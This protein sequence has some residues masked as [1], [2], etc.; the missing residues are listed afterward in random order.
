MAKKISD[1]KV[2]EAEILLGS[3]KRKLRFD[4]EAVAEAELWQK[5]NCGDRKRTGEKILEGVAKANLLDVKALIFGTAKSA[6]QKYCDAQF[7]KDFKLQCCAEYLDVLI[8][9]INQFLPEAE[10]TESTESPNG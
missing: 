7:E 8:D 1:F 10:K 6:N 2:F 3:K 5:R 4:N 9:G